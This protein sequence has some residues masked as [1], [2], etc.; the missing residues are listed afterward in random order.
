MPLIVETFPAEFTYSQTDF[1]E[2]YREA[3]HIYPDFWEENSPGMNNC[4]ESEISEH[5]ADSIAGYIREKE[6]F[7]EEI[8]EI[9]VVFHCFSPIISALIGELLSRKETIVILLPA[10]DTDLIR[11][12]F[13]H[14]I[15]P[16]SIPF[17]LPESDLSVTEFPSLHAFHSSDIPGPEKNVFRPARA[18]SPHTGPDLLGEL[19]KDFSAP[20]SRLNALL[21]RD[22]SPDQWREILSDFPQRYA[23]IREADPD[24][25]LSLLRLTAP[26]NHPH[27]IR[28]AEM[29]LNGLDEHLLID[30]LPAQN[31]DFPEF[32]S[33]LAESS[34]EGHLVFLSDEQL[35][36][37]SMPEKPSAAESAYFRCLALQG[38]FLLQ[39]I[40]RSPELSLSYSA[41]LDQRRQH[42]F[43]PLEMVANIR[44][45]APPP[46]S[47][48]PEKPAFSV[49]HIVLPELPYDRTEAMD[50][51][52]CPY[53]FAADYSLHDQPLFSRREDCLNLA[54]NILID[55]CW[56]LLA[57]T[58]IDR[59]ALAQ[60]MHE[61]AALLNRYLPLGSRMTPICCSAE[62]YIADYLAENG[63]IREYAPSHARMKLL[64]GQ[65]TF[66][67]EAASGESPHP[68]P[69]FARLVSGSSYRRQFPLHALPKVPDDRLKYAMQEGKFPPLSG[70]W[71]GY[72]PHKQ[73]CPNGG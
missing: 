73:F 61:Q 34:P 15:P 33:C 23:E 21:D 48:E 18:L 5:N 41:V 49:P 24:S 25:T 28:D 68:S 11:A 50:F 69:A 45:Y 72:C 19:E 20:F 70:P 42:L 29:L 55:W 8:R 65:A 44:K 59:A 10:M 57:G 58:D 13:D 30:H 64:F 3:F 51:F 31:E 36:P 66:T 1:P 39:L 40:G 9:P 56:R 67:T 62:A 22:S 37:P 6:D 35:L 16:E 7:M 47:A 4:C 26:F 17:P 52:L 32:F 63:K 38:H 12:V 2:K 46:A 43:A 60:T 53:R 54:E 71:C 27:A 14:D